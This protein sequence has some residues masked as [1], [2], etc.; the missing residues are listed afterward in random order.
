MKTYT[1]EIAM[2]NSKKLY[3][4]K[5]I[6]FT[7]QFQEDIDYN[8]IFYASCQHWNDNY[9]VV[10]IY[11]Y[12]DESYGLKKWCW[13]ARY[14]DEE[15]EH[16]SGYVSS[17]IEHKTFMRWFVDFQNRYINGLYRV[18]SGFN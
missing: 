11:F 1:N 5:V 17:M 8:D 12:V 16:E 9:E 13:R 7:K 10:D 3:P 4:Y 18:K 15:S 14:G 2:A 6:T